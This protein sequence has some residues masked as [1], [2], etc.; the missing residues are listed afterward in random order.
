VS[1]NSRTEL[2]QGCAPSGCTLAHKYVNLRNIKP[3]L[4]TYAGQLGLAVLHLTGSPIV[5]TAG[6]ADGCELENEHA[7]GI[8]VDFSLVEHGPT[9][10]PVII[11]MAYVLAEKYFVCIGLR[12]DRVGRM[13]LHVN[14]RT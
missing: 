1:S 11:G 14:A 6:Y 3:V 12:F 13:L 7:A 4:L 9:Q 5:I 8:A 2:P 10:R